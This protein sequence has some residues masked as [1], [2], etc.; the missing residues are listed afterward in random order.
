MEIRKRKRND[1]RVYT[2]E[3]LQ[4]LNL[5]VDPNLSENYLTTV[6]FCETLNLI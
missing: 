4:K 5:N 3:L 6:V 1:V 2:H